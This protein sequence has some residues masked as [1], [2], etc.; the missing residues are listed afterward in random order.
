MNRRHYLLFSLSLLLFSPESLFA[1]NPDSVKAYILGL[2]EPEVTFSLMY[3]TGSLSMEYIEQ[4]LLTPL[5]EEYIDERMKE[6]ELTGDPISLLTIA[7][8]Y[9]RMNRHSEGEKWMERAILETEE[10]MWKYPDSIEF[11]ET[12]S[13]LYL[14]NNQPDLASL[15]AK[16]I[17]DH[18]QDEISLFA[19]TMMYTFTGQYDLGIE[20][21]N[22]GL[23]LYPEEA[24]WYLIRMIHEFSK[25]MAAFNFGS[26][27]FVAEENRIDRSF[28]NKGAANYPDNEKVQL[29]A[30]LC[31]FFLFAYEEVLPTFYEQLGNCD[32]IETFKFK[33][34][35]SL[36]DKLEVH[37]QKVIKLSKQK[38]FKNWHSVHYTLGTIHMLRSET[39]KAIVYYEEAIDLMKPKYRHGQDNVYQ[40]YD[41]L[42]TCYRMLGDT[43]SAEKCAIIRATEEINLD[44]LPADYLNMALYRVMDKDFKA[45][46]ALLDQAIAIDSSAVDS[47]S[48]KAL[49]LM[50]D[51]ELH[52]AL[53]LLKLAES[54]QPNNLR[55]VRAVILF[56]LLK[57][58]S[59]AA[60]QL[61]GQLEAYDPTD[62]FIEDARRLLETE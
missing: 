42:V 35:S 33:I 38:A 54:I 46:I 11:V 20:L 49:L 29:A 50:L 58:E 61:I 41:N 45:A 1:Q 40:Y 43:A 7:Q 2:A 19:E 51:D 13:L 10:L 26:E 31:N 16:M 52:E 37:F 21:S 5:T 17:S 60:L 48:T 32:D 53:S 22:K 34:E 14:D 24:K 3:G 23:T 25:K 47:Y 44:P 4:P 12:A 30:V 62:F 9:K 18:N 59:A 56:R 15:T 55:T 6:Y 28:L 39:E 57:K 8:T 27:E 36:D